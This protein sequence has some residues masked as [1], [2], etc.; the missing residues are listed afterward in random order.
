MDSLPHHQHPLL[1]W[2]L[3]YKH[4]PTLIQHHHECQS[5]RKF[6][7][8]VVHAMGLAKFVT[9]CLHHFSAIQNSFTALKPAVLCLHLSVLLSS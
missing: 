7:L 4:G 2:Y 1:Q 3:C 5:L 9:T 6:T 8:G